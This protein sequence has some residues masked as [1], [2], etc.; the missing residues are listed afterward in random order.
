MRIPD[1]ITSYGEQKKGTEYPDES[2]EQKTFFNQLRKKYPQ[3]AAIAIHPKNE[4]KRKGRDFQTLSN[5]K[6]M[7]FCAGA[8]DIIIP[9][10][11]ALVIELKKQNGGR[12]QAG[13]VDYLT[14]A[15]EAGAVAVVAF[16]WEAA[17]QAVEDW[18]NSRPK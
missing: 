4:Q 14:A 15:Q 1:H 11:P 16:G 7:G 13:Q 18:H 12:W 10:G 3:Y 17:I 2:A 5:D 9:G 8:S 6:A